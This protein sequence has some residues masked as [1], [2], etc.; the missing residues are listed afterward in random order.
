MAELTRALGA[1]AL[2]SGL[3]ACGAVTRGTTAQPQG[4]TAPAPSTPVQKATA[5][6]ANPDSAI[7]ADFNAR[8]DKYVKFKRLLLKEAP[9]KE[10]ENPSEITARQEVLAAKIRNIR[11]NAKQGDI[12]TPQVAAMFKRL[13]YPEL[14]GA[15]G[16][17]TKDEIKQEAPAVELKVNATYPASQPL[18]TVPPNLLANLPQL[19]RDVEYRIVGRHL[20][21]RDVDA[22]IMVD[23]MFNAIR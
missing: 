8:L 9:L 2:A 7:L 22:N 10:T 12:F 16:R 13:M 15:E 3:V 21:L 1:L 6:P 17:E 18:T 11:K 20:L 5:S 4:Q 14:K 23:Y 19:P